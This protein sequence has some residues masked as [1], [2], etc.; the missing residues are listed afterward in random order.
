[1]HEIFRIRLYLNFIFSKKFFEKSS[2]F[3]SHFEILL[4][5]NLTFVRIY[6]Y[7]GIL[8]ANLDSFSHDFFD[9][10][11][12]KKKKRG[13]EFRRKLYYLKRK[14]FGMKFF[15]MVSVFF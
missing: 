5:Y 3:F 2:I 14:N 8:I 1:L 7:D 15:L 13:K 12:V 6:Y 9:E 4:K 10:F 11:Y